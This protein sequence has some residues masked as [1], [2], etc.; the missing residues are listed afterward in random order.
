M[1]VDVLGRR[2]V[3]R[4][5]DALEHWCRD[6]APGGW[7]MFAACGKH[8]PE[9]WQP[10]LSKTGR[11][12]GW[13]RGQLEKARS[14]CRDCPV[15]PQCLAHAVEHVETGVWGGLTEHERDELRRRKRGQ[16]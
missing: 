9:I 2:L 4:F 7:V 5:T 10:E 15:R 16:S 14:V 1:T 12:G 6:P 13:H 3:P 11:H 8:D